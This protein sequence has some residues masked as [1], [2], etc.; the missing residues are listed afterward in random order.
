MGPSLQ[1]C[2]IRS[3]SC[4]II[5]EQVNRS[6]ESTVDS[7]VTIS[8]ISLKKSIIVS[9]NPL[10]LRDNSAVKY[11]GYWPWEIACISETRGK[12]G[13]WNCFRQDRVAVEDEAVG[14]HVSAVRTVWEWSRPARV[15]IPSRD[16][17]AGFVVEEGAV[18]R[19]AWSRAFEEVRS[20][21]E[22][23]WRD[24]MASQVASGLFLV[25]FVDMIAMV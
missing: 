10:T 7:P 20:S 3:H 19:G 25:C 9:N 8:T 1:S 6:C 14:P 24:L 22:V 13:S 18:R 17:E 21:I 15:A 4:I 23:V 12:T 11:S 2:C 5:P 16:A